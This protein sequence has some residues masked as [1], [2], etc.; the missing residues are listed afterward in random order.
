MKNS[1][2]IRRIIAL[3]IILVL[4]PV[5]TF[6][7]DA[8]LEYEFEMINALQEEDGSVLLVGR[9]G[10]PANYDGVVMKLDAEGRLLWQMN[11]ASMGSDLYSGIV[12]CQNNQYIALHID[13]SIPDMAYLEKVDSGKVTCVYQ[14]D[15]E[16]SFNIF[17]A[18]DGFLLLT[19]TSF[20][21]TSLTYFDLN[22]QPVWR[23]TFDYGYRFNEVLTIADCYVGI[24][25]YY[26][27]NQSCARSLLCKISHDNSSIE[28]FS[29]YENAIF[30]DAS[31]VNGNIYIVGDTDPLEG[32]RESFFVSYNSE[33]GFIR[34][35][36]SYGSNREGNFYSL[37]PDD[38]GFV[39]ACSVSKSEGNIHW[40]NF[41]CQGNGV[42]ASSTQC[43]TIR[44]VNRA[45]LF[46]Q[47]DRIFVVVCGIS[48]TGNLVYKT[49]VLQLTNK[50]E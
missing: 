15:N 49:E 39:V 30:T 20:T 16:Q 47:K 33:D 50:C 46:R 45:L 4:T 35:D 9:T 22:L 24:G 40:I 13:T 17:P 14:V 36:Y 32:W 12:S 21:S 48:Q 1:R 29:P 34:N 31:F 7:A 43:N 38:N 19:G 28:V 18:K 27:D 3:S 44:I 5:V 41:D 25:Y 26:P 8:L 6:G 11:E 42:R 2:V 10:L 23:R 37:I